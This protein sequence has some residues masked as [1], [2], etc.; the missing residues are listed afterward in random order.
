MDANEYRTRWL[1]AHNRL[2]DLVHEIIGKASN[3]DP[4][5]LEK[6]NEQFEAYLADLGDAKRVAAMPA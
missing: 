5:L 1:M 2:H 3:I 4:A 6:V